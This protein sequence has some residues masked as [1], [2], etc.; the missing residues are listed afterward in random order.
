MLVAF[1][2]TLSMLS[3][4]SKL[5]SRES[6]QNQIAGWVL[7]IKMVNKFTTVKINIYKKS[8]TKFGD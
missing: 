8:V 1:F 6:F 4:K 2:M 3:G 7:F 5:I